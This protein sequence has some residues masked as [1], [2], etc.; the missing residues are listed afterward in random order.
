MGFEFYKESY[1]G[2]VKEITLGQ[3]NKAVTVGGE[4]GYPFVRRNT[5]V[6]AT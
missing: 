1:S 6:I 5:P 3:G 4:T 2:T